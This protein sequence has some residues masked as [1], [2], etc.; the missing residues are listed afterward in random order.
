MRLIVVA[1]LVV[2]LFIHYVVSSVVFSGKSL[3]KFF[4]RLNSSFSLS[5]LRTCEKIY[6]HN[7]ICRLNGK[8]Q[9]LYPANY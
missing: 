6:M 8:N 9:A 3:L 2:L 4:D 7:P 1:K 5:L